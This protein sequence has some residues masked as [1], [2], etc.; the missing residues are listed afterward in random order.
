MASAGINSAD[1]QQFTSPTTLAAKAN[2]RDWILLAQFN[3]RDSQEVCFGD[4][5]MLYYW[6]RKQDLESLN[7]NNV[8]LILQCY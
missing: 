8:W 3:S 4:A 6:I 2:A 7:F 5:G 1:F